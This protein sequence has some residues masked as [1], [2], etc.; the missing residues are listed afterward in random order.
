MKPVISMEFFPHG[1]VGISQEILIKTST[2]EQIL[3]FLAA[4]QWLY[5]LHCHT[6][7]HLGF[8]ALLRILQVLSCNMG[9]RSGIILIIFR[10]PT[11]PPTLPT[12][13]VWNFVQCTHISMNIWSNFDVWCPPPTPYCPPVQRVCAVSSPPSIHFFCAV[14]PPM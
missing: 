5:T 2:F 4:K 1:S 10:P 11:Q 13:N 8:S 9:P 7:L 14:S 12:A 6:G 3:L